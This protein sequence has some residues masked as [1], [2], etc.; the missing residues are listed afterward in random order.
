MMI[1]LRRWYFGGTLNS[2]WSPCWLLSFCL[3]W[4]EWLW[5]CWLSRPLCIWGEK[6]GIR[7]LKIPHFLFLPRFK[8]LF[9]VAVFRFWF[10][11]RINIPWIAASLWTSQVVLVVKNLPAN[12]GNAGLSL[13][14][15]DPWKLE[16]EPHSSF[17]AWKIPWAEEPSRLNPIGP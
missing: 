7:Q 4:L 3:P 11:F 12:A 1:I 8:Q 2:F 13:D 5:Y 14:Q 15:E 16:M 6:M 17:L 10:S 9:T